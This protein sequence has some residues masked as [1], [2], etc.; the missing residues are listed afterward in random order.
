M[1]MNITETFKK[2]FKMLNKKEV[3]VLL[4]PDCKTSYKS[5]EPKIE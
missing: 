1:H 4:F 2:S 5:V 3:G